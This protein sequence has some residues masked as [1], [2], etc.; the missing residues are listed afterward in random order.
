MQ[1]ILTYDIYDNGQGENII[2]RRP[3]RFTT[4]N[5]EAT[6]ERMERLLTRRVKDQSGKRYRHITVCFN[7]KEKGSLT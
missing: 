1:E 2:K 5:I 3:W 6:R 4:G 7:R